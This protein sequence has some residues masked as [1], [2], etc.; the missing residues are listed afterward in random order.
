MGRGCQRWEEA[1]R[2][3]GGRGR[4]HI[5]QCGMGQ[6]TGK[7]GFKDLILIKIFNFYEILGRGCSNIRRCGMG[8]R[9]K[10]GLQFADFISVHMERSKIKNEISLAEF[11]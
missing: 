10:Q 9:T 5:R 2:G 3:G 7:S 1:G 6:R 4:R 11:K 8:Q